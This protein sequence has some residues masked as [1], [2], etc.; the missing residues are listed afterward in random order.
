MACFTM[1]SPKDSTRVLVVSN[2]VSQFT[3]RPGAE[4]PHIKT[5]TDA[6]LRLL[7]E[8]LDR[9]FD[10]VCVVPHMDKLRIAFVDAFAGG[11]LYRRG[12]SVLSGSPLVMIEAVQNA[13]NRINT[14]RKKPLKI[15]AKFYFVE[16]DRD[17]IQY[18]KDVIRDTTMPE[19]I[20]NSISF[21]NLTA[22]SAL[23]NIVK[24][25][26]SWSRSGRSIFFLD[27]CGYKDVSNKDIRLIYQALPKSEV[28][29][30][31]NFGAIYDYMNTNAEFLAA[32]APLEL[33]T[34]NIR[35]LL[36]ERQYQAGRYF[37]GRLL[38]QIL[39]TNVGSTY[40]SRFFLHST[41]SN[42]DMWF[43][44]YSK[45]PRSRLVMSEAHWA[46]KNCSITQG[47]AGLDMV[48]FSPDWENQLSLDFGFEYSDEGLV[49]KA[50]IKELPDWLEQY[51]ESSAPTFDTLLT[52]L[53]DGTVAT[54]S[55]FK[56]ALRTLE[57]EREIVILTPNNSQKDLDAELRAHHRLIVSR[58]RQLFRQNN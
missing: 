7:R 21:L 12:G 53:A 28:I 58:Q 11:G 23:P 45:V 25:I 14:R 36:N 54:E 48:G 39:K 37:A 46:I 2:K 20:R 4:P 47:R 9:Y 31:Y 3:W 50:L 10:V 15:E 51:D 30:T 27:Q 57:G 29:V 42:R 41:E 49:H 52:R 33:T 56:R 5:H 19:D 38:G 6:K 40:A 55:H 8:Y 16:A 18:L 35:S 44:H 43:V 32:S 1:T 22:T 34:E 13:V 17:V 26:A 24:D